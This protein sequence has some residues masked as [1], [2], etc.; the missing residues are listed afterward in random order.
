MANSIDKVLLLISL[1]MSNGAFFF[2]P[3]FTK[4]THVLRLGT[5]V[6]WR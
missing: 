1:G 5:Y 6:N 4:S 3:F 2:L